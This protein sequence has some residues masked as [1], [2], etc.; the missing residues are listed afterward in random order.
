M[1][2]AD[3]RG[4]REL[5][6]DLPAP[7]LLAGQPGRPGLPSPVVDWQEYWRR[8]KEAH[9]E[10]VEVNGR[11]VFPDGWSYARDDYAGP[12]FPPPESDDLTRLL[13]GYWLTRLRIVANEAAWL[14]D[15]C[16]Q[17][18]QL[19]AARSMPL[20]QRVRGED[21]RVAHAPLDPDAIEEGR[22]AWLRDDVRLCEA[23]LRHLQEGL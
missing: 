13:I 18:R 20:P 1:R 23:N 7:A 19:R 12:E 16:Q 11:L 17:L 4:G 3:H 21:G 9:G 8:F 2:P 15:L 6:P 10:P 22:L 14:E 5:T